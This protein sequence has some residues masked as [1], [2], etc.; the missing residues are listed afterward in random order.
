[1]II[2]RFTCLDELKGKNRSDPLKILAVL[3]KTGR[4][5]CF[6]VDNRMAT[7]MTWLCNSSGWIKT[8]HFEMVMDADGHGHHQRDL[9]PWTIVTLTDAGRL[10]LSRP[11]RNTPENS[12][13]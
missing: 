4:F 11:A 10:A 6:D 3:E 13:E 1:M 2:D 12:N 7:A 8:Q 9:Y 5:S